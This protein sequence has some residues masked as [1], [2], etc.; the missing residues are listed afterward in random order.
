MGQYFKFINYDKKEMFSANC[1]GE[2]IKTNYNQMIGWDNLTGTEKYLTTLAI[3]ILLRN[4]WSSDLVICV[5][6]NGDQEIISR[7]IN[8]TG[9]HIISKQSTKDFKS[10]DME[11][12]SMIRGLD[13][14][15]E[16]QD[17]FLDR[18]RSER[19]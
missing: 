19:E 17:E 16:T 11:V 15:F 3:E 9:Y 8:T 14:E 5:G 10:I 1:L 12:T 4:H 6:D 2:E 18:C 7:G 13:F